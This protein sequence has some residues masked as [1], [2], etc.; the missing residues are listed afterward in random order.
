MSR[1]FNYANPWQTKKQAYMSS[2]IEDTVK[3]LIEFES[4]LDRAMAGASDAKKKMLKDAADWVAR[5]NASAVSKAQQIAS[6]MVAKARAEAEVESES[7]RK[8][9]ESALKAFEASISKRKDKAAEHVVL[10]LLGEQS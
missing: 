4:E 5:A 7:I 6:G 1:T 2:V 9:G 8:R 3:V 10:R